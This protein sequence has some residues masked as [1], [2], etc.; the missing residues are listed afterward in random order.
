MRLFRLAV[1]TFLLL[2]CSTTDKVT[3]RLV[4]EERGLYKIELGN[5]AL[6]ID[7]SIGGRINTLTFDGKDFLTDS[8]VNNFNWGSTFWF[9]PQSEWKWPPPAEIDNKPYTVAYDH[10]T[11]IMHSPVD[12]KTGLEVTK[13]ISANRRTQS[14]RL[15][16]TIHNRSKKPQRVAPWEVTRVKTN[17]IALFP[18]G[19]GDRRGGLIP[20]TME[21]DGISWFAYHKDQLPV[22]GDRQLY[23]DGSEGWLAQINDGIVLVKKFKDVPQE[24]NA[25]NEGEI[26]WYASPVAPGKSYVEIEH[27]GPYE[28]LKPGDVMLWEVEWFLRKLP[29]GLKAEAGNPDIVRFI[30]KVIE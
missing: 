6:G 23:S 30:R 7:P 16:Y 27:Q 21:W 18:I 28:T 11:L 29:E 19:K 24:K 13:R 5:Q 17:G 26:E 15:Q 3:S 22:K 9:S 8:T 2:S 1:P 10:S 4:K 14:F 12:P 20:F 25:P